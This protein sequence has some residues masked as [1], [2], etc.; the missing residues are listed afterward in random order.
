[1]V[2]HQ[3]SP[4]RFPALSLHVYTRSQDLG[5]E[6][7]HFFWSKPGAPEMNLHFHCNPGTRILKYTL[8]IYPKLFHFSNKETTPLVVD[9]EWILHGFEIH[10]LMFSRTIVISI[11]DTPQN[12]RVLPGFSGCKT[13]FFRRLGCLGRCIRRAQQKALYKEPFWRDDIYMGVSENRG[14]P[15]WMVYN[16]QLY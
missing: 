16:G 1:M 12:L 11:W 5:I 6:M 3:K 10:Q 14:T 2:F 4:Q 13:R 8:K 7:L 15:K 9:L